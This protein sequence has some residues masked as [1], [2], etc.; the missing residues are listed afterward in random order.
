M[1]R[2]LNM[3]GISHIIDVQGEKMPE[4]IVEVLEAFGRALKVN[5]FD[6]VHVVDSLYRSNL[7]GTCTPCS[8]YR[9]AKSWD[10]GGACFKTNECAESS[11]L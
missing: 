9:D 5:A 3:E 2:G 1:V 8:W 6:S 4:L 7:Q 10:I 11:E